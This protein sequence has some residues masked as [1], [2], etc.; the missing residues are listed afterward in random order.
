MLNFDA[1]V[2]KMIT[3]H[4]RENR[5]S[6]LLRPGSPGP[7]GA[8]RVV[9]C[10]DAMRDAPDVKLESFEIVTNSISCATMANVAMTMNPM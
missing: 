7:R 5:F 1:D 6:K 4:Q 8:S 9:V 3:R 10:S 2:K